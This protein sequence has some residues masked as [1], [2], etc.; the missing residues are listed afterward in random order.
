MA[1]LV[2]EAERAA[3][4][5]L[6]GVVRTSSVLTGGGLAMWRECNAGEWKASAAELSQDLDVLKVPHEVVVAFRPPR[7]REARRRKGQE[8][9]V[10]FAKLVRWVPS[11][12]QPIDE[13]PAETPGFTFTYCEP[14][15]SGMAM[16][17]LSSFAAEWPA[18]SVK[19]AE[20]MGLLCAECR[21][22]L[23]ARGAERRLAYNLPVEPARRRLVCGDCCGNGLPELER[24]A[25]AG[26]T[27]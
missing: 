24:L 4:R 16:L 15:P 18:W 8:V 20:A 27:L 25:A 19:Q 5:R 22:D 23:R 7:A 13:L 14:R 21:F 17:V 26:P 2:T 11:L 3:Q 10:A 6:V 12:Q 9:R 1:Q